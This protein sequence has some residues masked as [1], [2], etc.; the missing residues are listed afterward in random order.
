MKAGT[1]QTRGGTRDGG[2]DTS[3]RTTDT[4][5]TRSEERAAGRH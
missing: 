4:A 5:M 3:G 2:R 1:W